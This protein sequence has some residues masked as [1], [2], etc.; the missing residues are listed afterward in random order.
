MSELLAKL[1]LERV[2]L[3]LRRRDK[4]PLFQITGIREEAFVILF[5]R[6]FHVIIT[7][8]TASSVEE[9][10]IDEE[11]CLSFNSC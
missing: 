11:E 6:S 1:N 5:V 8:Y 7:T 4:Q 10:V 2:H 9:G 3:C